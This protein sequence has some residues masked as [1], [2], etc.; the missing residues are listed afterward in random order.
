MVRFLI[1]ALA[2]FLCLLPAGLAILL[3]RFTGWLLHSILRFRVSMVRMQLRVVYGDSKTDAELDTL[4]RKIYRHLGLLLVEV[5]MI[6]KMPHERGEELVH[7]ENREHMDRALAKGKGAFMLTGHLGNWEIA[8]FRMTDDGLKLHAISKDMKSGAGNGM[9]D[10]IRGRTGIT[11]YIARNS[12]RNILKAL[13]SNEIVVM[14]ADQ[15]MT[16][17]E[18]VFVEFLGQQACTMKS[19]AVLAAR[20]G[21]A[22]V[23]LHLYRDADLKHH[24]GVFG[25]EIEFEAVS[26][27]TEVNYRHNTARYTKAIGDMVLKQPDQW[28]WIH[29][30]WKTRPEGEERNP[31]DY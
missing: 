23:P 31:F 7:L 18:G 20:T 8:G 21:A 25:P 19:V 26:D 30:R 11:T 12:M 16:A 9:R 29:K 28:M 24:H 5:L 3:G 4:L 14:L 10:M 2:W 15:N 27:D 6:P 22:V 17:D 1:A 13:K